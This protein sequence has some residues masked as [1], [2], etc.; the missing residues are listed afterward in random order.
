MVDLPASEEALRDFVRDGVDNLNLQEPK[1]LPHTSRPEF[2]TVEIDKTNYDFVSPGGVSRWG[3]SKSGQ[4]EITGF[5]IVNSNGKTNELLVLQPARFQISLKAIEAGTYSCRYAFNISN[6][7]G[8][9]AF[10]VKSPADNFKMLQGS[11]RMVDVVFNPLQL[12]PGEY[13]VSVV[14]VLDYGP[15]EQ[16]NNADRYDLLSRSFQFKVELP[17]SWSA[18]NSQFFHSAEWHFHDS[19]L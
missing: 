4:L 12:G 18:L 11:C 7:Q 14:A 13:M 16:T 8:Q 10:S 5:T 6:Q 17:S 15:I 3:A 1:F 9:T 2:P 19:G